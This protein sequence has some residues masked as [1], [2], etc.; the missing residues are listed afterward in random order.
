MQSI[1]LIA[2]NKIQGQ[3]YISKLSKDINVHPLDTHILEQQDWVVKKKQKEKIGIGEV[4]DFQK[5]LLLKPI[6]GKNKLGAIFDSDYLTLDAQNALLKLLEE[7]PLSATIVM[8]AKNKEHLLP[9]I[10]S[11]CNIILLNKDNNTALYEEK[12]EFL[13]IFHKL[14]KEGVGKRLK[15]AQDLCVDKAKTLEW[16]ENTILAIRSEMLDSVAKQNASHKNKLNLKTIRSFKK[17][18]ELLKSTNATPRFVLE[19]LL[20]FL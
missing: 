12:E 9:T 13:G 19:N 7:P 15:F 6:Y 10:L 3:E 1:I 17:A 5:K 2:N 8:I 18:E 20:L 11:R 4:R 16:I 14:Q